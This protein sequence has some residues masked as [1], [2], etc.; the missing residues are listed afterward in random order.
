MSSR[1]NLKKKPVP[2][3]FPD[4]DIDPNPDQDR[5]QDPYPDLYLASDQDQASYP[6]ADLSQD[7]G[8]FPD[9]APEHEPIL[10]F[11]ISIIA[12]YIMLL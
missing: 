5:D 8:Y 7:T 10:C 1:E 9:F 6:D 2:H 3:N 4:L 12:G 11:L